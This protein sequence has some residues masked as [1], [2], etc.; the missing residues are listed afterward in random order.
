MII[1]KLD[2]LNYRNIE[3]LCLEPDAAM[4][5]IYGENAQGKTNLLEGIYLFTGSKSFR[6]SRDAELIR[7]GE[8]SKT[9][10]ITVDFSTRYDIYC[11]KLAIKENRTAFLNQIPLKTTREL[12]EYFPAM[13][14]APK[15]LGLVQSGPEE[16]RSFLDQG[17]FQLKTK[18][19]ELLKNY[20]TALDQRNAILKNIR[21]NLDWVINLE[22]W[23][24]TLAALG[25]KII[26]Q[27][28]QYLK[29]LEKYAV[30][31]YQGLS[32]TTEILAMTLAR[33]IDTDSNDQQVI[34]KKLLQSLEANREKDIA[35]G[36]TTAGPHRDDLIFTINGLP[37]KAFGSQGQQ[38]SVALAVKMGEAY[39]L[40][41]VY[42]EAPVILLDDVMSELD[43]QRQNYILNHI[44]QF[45]VFITCCDKD[46]ILRMKKGK[47]F[48]ISQGALISGGET[49]CTYT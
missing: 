21:A 47:A 8:E 6:G 13:L 23:D 10:E 32:G 27:R 12:G 49:E 38:R 37:V 11:G 39:I 7:F 42:E 35:C 41:E 22:I 15:D 24:V 4:N 46:A 31:F 48:Y 14:F 28:E 43:Q 1:K 3:K 16:R 9:A 33:T 30:P 44:N 45:Q 20:R 2:F 26:Y 34:E 18:Y 25:T 5:I 40:E 29:R 36:F 17:L 19:G